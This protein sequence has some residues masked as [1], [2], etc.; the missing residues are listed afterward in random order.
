MTPTVNNTLG[1]GQRQYL[2]QTVTEEGV[3]L[4][5]E[6][7]EGNVVMFISLTTPNPNE[8][9][10]DFRLDATEGEG[11][12][13]IFIGPENFNKTG[14]TAEKYGVDGSRRRRQVGLV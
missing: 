2:Q 9:F 4:G 11:T 3:T 14:N 7:S 5:I 10:H 8:A 13:E 6:A 1:V 12:A